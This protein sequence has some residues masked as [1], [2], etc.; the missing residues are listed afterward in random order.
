MDAPQPEN[1]DV[2]LLAARLRQS[3]W[4]VP[5]WAALECARPF[6]WLLGQLCLVGEPAARALGA[7]GW[8]D[9]ITPLLADPRQL[10]ALAH[11]LASE[12]ER[13]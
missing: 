8:L 3:G 10:D 12:Q 2:A 13:R 6:R 1:P 4:A 11:A 5:A 9:A 7:G